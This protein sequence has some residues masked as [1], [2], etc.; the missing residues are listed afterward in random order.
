LVFVQIWGMMDR[1]LEVLRRVWGYGGFRPVQGQVVEAV[2][3]GR[4]V[5]ALLP[6]G[7]GKSLCYQVPGL[8][9]GGVT[10]VVSPLIALMRDQVEGL[11]RRGVGAVA[12]DSTLPKVLRE[13]ALQEA[14]E[15]QVQFLYASPERLVMESFQEALRGLPIRL[16]AVDEAH[17]ISQWGHDFRGAYLELGS[18]R[19]VIGEQVPWIALT[20]TA[21][22]RVQKDII[23]LLGLREPVVIR[24]P[25][26]RPN[27]YYAVVY[28]VDKDK[29][30][31]Q[32]VKK[33]SGSGIVYVSSQ[34]GAVQVA[35]RLRSWGVSA[36]AYHAGMASQLRSA[37]QE[38]WIQEK[39][40]IIVATSAFGMGIDKPDTRFVLHYDLAAEPEAYFQEVGRA[41][42]DGEL[43]YAVALYSPQDALD[44]ERRIQEKY[45][46]HAFLQAFYRQ[47]E[48]WAGAERRLRISLS[49]L[50]QRAQVSAHLLR[51][52]L[53]LLSQERFLEVRGEVGQ[54]A[55]LR[56]RVG[57]EVWQGKP[58]SPQAEWILRLGGA[59]LFRE[60]VYVDLQDWAQEMGVGYE[61]LYRELEG[62]RRLGWIEHDALPE[63]GLDISLRGRPTPTQWETIRHKY[64]DLLRGAQ[65]R[66]RF[67][68]GYYQ[69][70]SIC[71]AQ[72][73]L[74][75]FD[76]EIPPCGQ[77]D[78]CRGYYRVEEVSES[79]L[80]ALQ[81]ELA[82]YMEV[83]RP[84]REVQGFLRRRFP[85]SAE[86]IL[87]ILIAEG[88]VELLSDWR[89]RWRKKK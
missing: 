27:F 53:H 66:L 81:A 22:A 48:G 73:L 49:Q 9:F 44:M 64:R 32:S 88:Q 6:T 34:R 87:E 68:L 35:E 84:V 20:A 82:A 39:V 45:P 17:C 60:G 37:V 56:S 43:A 3:A 28:D 71:R 70:R 10:L 36:A 38:A 67:M 77:C 23:E 54:R 51:Q 4:D 26:Y 25:F 65:V 21:T 29:R 46:A 85:K 72:Y 1:A 61:E 5:L 78:V 79:T 13:K 89:L 11:R 76:E 62:L 2:L 40:R 7:G 69:Q 19:A 86:Q 58:L 12:I 41:G 75:Y 80:E 52:A 31:L 16:V 59:A 42:R 74:R 8:V 15:G 33:L 18:L 30:L 14:A 83:P 63:G 50:T 47:L 55:Y 24:Q 57:P